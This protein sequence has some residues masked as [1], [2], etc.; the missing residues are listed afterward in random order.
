MLDLGRSW[1][2]SMQ[3]QYEKIRTYLQGWMNCFVIGMRYYDAVEPDQRL[4]RRIRMY[5]WKQWRRMKKRVGELM[6]R[7]VG[8]RPAVTAGLSRR[9]YW[10]LAKIEAMNVGLSNVYLTKE[11]LTSIRTLWIKIHHAATAR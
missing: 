8:E 11:G 4:R 1:G 3:Y 7:G 2:V 5:C 6:K 9:S 10:H